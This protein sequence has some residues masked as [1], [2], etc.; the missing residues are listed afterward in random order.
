MNLNHKLCFT[1][2][3]DLHFDSYLAEKMHSGS[4]NGV[5][6]NGSNWFLPLMHF[7]LLSCAHKFIPYLQDFFLKYQPNQKLVVLKMLQ[8]L[9]VYDEDLFQNFMDDLTKI[10]GKASLNLDDK[11]K[12]ICVTQHP[13]SGKELDRTYD[14]LE[15][16]EFH[17]KHCAKDQSNVT[18]TFRDK[19]GNLVL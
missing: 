17:L 7:K 19:L 14:L 8:N 2:S 11:I 1:N 18:Q 13:I 15:V 10:V 9:S 5:M 6:T 16:I 3:E 4:S 12:E